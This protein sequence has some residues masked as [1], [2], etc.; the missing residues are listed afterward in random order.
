LICRERS[1]RFLR[2]DFIHNDISLFLLVIPGLTRNPVVRWI[3]AFAGM[4]RCV[5]IATLHTLRIL[6]WKR[7][8]PNFKIRIE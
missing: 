8:N 2:W 5:A 6:V 7:Q 3:P 1:L 4:T